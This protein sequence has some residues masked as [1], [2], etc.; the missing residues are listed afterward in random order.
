MST[1]RTPI[2]GISSIGLMS[3]AILLF[4]VAGAGWFATGYLGEKA[5]QEI[6]ENSEALIS[7]HCAH[8]TAEFDK[9]ER[10]VQALSG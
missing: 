8:L 9:V 5:G 7:L 4:I 3:Y 6:R 2:N 10:A 1:V